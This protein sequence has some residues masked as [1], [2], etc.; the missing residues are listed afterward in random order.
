MGEQQDLQP[1]DM[2][3]LNGVTADPFQV[4]VCS[5]TRAVALGHFQHPNTQLK[6]L[7]IHILNDTWNES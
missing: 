3:A 1:M 4:N 2:D 6:W 7:R 5:F